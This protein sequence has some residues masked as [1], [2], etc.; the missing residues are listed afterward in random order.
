MP[1]TVR[2]IKILRPLAL[3]DFALLWTAMA[4]SLMGDGVYLVAIAWQVYDLSNAPTALSIVGLAWTLPMVLFLLVGGVISDR[5]DRRKVMIASDVVRGL[6]IAALGV[7]SVAGAIELA[8]VIGL[9]AVYGIGEAFFGPAF[10]AIVPE[11][12]PPDLLVEANS[13]DHFVRPLT[14][15][16]AG[17]ALGGLAVEFL[18]G[19]GGAFLL[20]AG[21]FALSALCLLAVR[22]RPVMEREASESGLRQ[23]KEGYAFV[24][25]QTWLWAT[26]GAAALSLFFYWGP[27]EVLVPY[28][29]RNELSGDA[30]DLGLVFAFGGGGA[31]L[32]SLWVAQVGLP[33]RHI[34]FM[35]SNWAVTAG[36]IVGFAFVT[37]VRQAMAVGFVGGASAAAGLVVWGTLMHRLVPAHMLGRVTSFDWMIS[38]AL[39]PVS[40]AITGPVATAIGAGPTLLGAGVLGCLATVA[41]MFIPGLYDTERNAAL[42]LPVDEAKSNEEARL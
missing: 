16:L 38:I 36:S 13:L 15:Q 33:R 34:L 32:A 23:I 37:S 6:A 28:I 17:P 31:V 35:Y 20:D 4:V 25:A 19:P 2:R 10:G 30:G 3:R 22:N 21:T 11:I 18:G 41:F 42:A 27:F 14:F 24:R 29:V 26:L 1:P 9:V 40:F 8:H 5:F 12:V 7:L 39:V